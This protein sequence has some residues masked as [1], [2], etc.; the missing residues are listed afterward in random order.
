[1]NTPVQGS[2]QT[3]WDELK[4]VCNEILFFPNTYL[5]LYIGRE[6]RH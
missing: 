5:C 1:M 3:R 6:Y 2:N 4:S